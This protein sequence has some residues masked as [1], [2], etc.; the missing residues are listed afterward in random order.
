MKLA[1]V[2]SKH[3]VCLDRVEKLMNSLPLSTQLITTPQSGPAQ[4]AFEQAKITGM[5]R[6]IV[7]AIPKGEHSQAQF[8]AYAHEQ[9]EKIIS[10]IDMLVCFW[11][12]D[13]VSIK[14]LI[15]M[16]AAAGKIIFVIPDKV[17]EAVAKHQMNGIFIAASTL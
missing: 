3:Y 5:A 12:G 15:G 16:A 13:E 7:H 11:N 2:G 4:W 10:E 6:P 1:V 8:I 9:R 14:E 17:N